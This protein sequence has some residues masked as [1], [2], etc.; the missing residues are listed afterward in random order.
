M[1]LEKYTIDKNSELLHALEKIDKNKKGFLIVL[2]NAKVCGVITDGDI[3]RN[4]IK[5]E[6]IK[7]TIEG[8]YTN[9]FTYLTTEDGF[10]KVVEYFKGSNIL[11]LPILDEN[12][13]LK[14]IITKKNLHALLLKNIEYDPFY[15]FDSIDDSVLEHE[16]YPRLWGF[17]KTT[18]LN[19]FCQCKIIT[20][21]PKS[22]ISLQKHLR[23]EEH[24]I[25]VNGY[26]KAIVDTEEIEI[27]AGSHLHIPKNTIHR[28]INTSETEYL[29]LTEVQLG[30][31]FGEDDIIRIEDEYDR[32]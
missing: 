13:N 12:K 24:W 18:V 27:K 25:I 29:I 26:G 2:D 23:R 16:I 30:D 14:N 9:E 32:I 19:D 7:K 1:P 8:I 22:S 15:D 10:S 28:L 3:R 11:F 6:S 31:Y 20:L 5:T 21:K 17:Y 4:L